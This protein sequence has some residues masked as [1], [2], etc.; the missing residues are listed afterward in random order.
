[1]MKTID[2]L[3]MMWSDLCDRGFDA[4]S[5][6][7]KMLS[8]LATDAVLGSNHIELGY[9]I[10]DARRKA[11]SEEDHLAINEIEAGLAFTD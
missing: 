11:E 7:M 9:I 6:P 4:E 1:M 2:Y 8:V 5:I 10:D 3:D